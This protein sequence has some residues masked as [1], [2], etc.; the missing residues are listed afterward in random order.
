MLKKLP[1]QC[2]Y[3]KGARKTLIKLTYSV[4]IVNEQF[5]RAQ[6]PKA[7]KDTHGLTGFFDLL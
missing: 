3:K 6:I 1:K 2:W 4:N 7:Q 5:L